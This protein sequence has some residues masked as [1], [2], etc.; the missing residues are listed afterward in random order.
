MSSS[1]KI[2]RA[3]DGVLISGKA[4]FAAKQFQFVAVKNPAAAVSSAHEAP[5]FELADGKKGYLLTR[6]VLDNE[7]ASGEQE[8]PLANLIFGSSVDA[9]GNTVDGLLTPN[10]KGDVVTA[11]GGVLELE[12]EGEDYLD[13]SIDETATVGLLLTTAAGKL[14]L[15]SSPYDSAS[16]QV[17]GRIIGLLAPEDGTNPVRILVELAV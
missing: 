6:R 2:T 10:L 13:D 15:A 4:D 11:R 16:E 9:D 12:A 14:A 3:L 7:G 17:V 1:L 8:Q 5:E